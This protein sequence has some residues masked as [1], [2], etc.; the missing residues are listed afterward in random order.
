MMFVL[1]KM[2]KKMLLANML[3]PKSCGLHSKSLFVTHEKP[4]CKLGDT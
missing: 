3:N 4:D 2:G 1:M